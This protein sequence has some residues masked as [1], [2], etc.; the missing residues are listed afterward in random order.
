MTVSIFQTGDYKFL[1]LKNIHW[2]RILAKLLLCGTKTPSSKKRS[3]DTIMFGL[4]STI[5]ATHWPHFLYDGTAHTLPRPYK[6]CKPHK[7]SWK[8]M[9]QH[10]F[11]K[12]STVLEYLVFQYFSTIE[13]TQHT[14]QVL[15]DLEGIKSIVPDCLRIANT[16]FTQITIATSNGNNNMETHIDDGDII[17]AV[18]HLGDVKKGGSTLYFDKLEDSE[19]GKETCSVVFEHGRIQI[20]FLIK[21]TIVYSHLKV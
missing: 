11:Q 16:I 12:L 14:L 9:K 1:W 10:W 7:I 8:R 17:C 5:T 21:C 18:L 19:K 20:C 15:S 2:Y 6:N 13:K 3:K 4:K